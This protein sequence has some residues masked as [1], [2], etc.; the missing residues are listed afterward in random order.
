MNHTPRSRTWF[1][2]AALY[3]AI[4]VMLGVTMGASGDHSLFA[5]HAHINLLGWV[6]MALFGVI[7]AL[8]PS[9]TEGR[10]AAVQFWTYNLGVPVMLGALTLRLKGFASIEPL[11]GVASILIGVSVLLFAWLVFSRIGVVAGYLSRTTGESRLS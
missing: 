3:F 1:R 11:I 9:M 6:S 8:H 2:L 7:G 10:A 4:G 5:V